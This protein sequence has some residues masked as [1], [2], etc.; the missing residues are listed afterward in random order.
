MMSK[1]VWNNMRSSIIMQRDEGLLIDD[2]Q[3]ENFYIQECMAELDYSGTECQYDD[4]NIIDPKTGNPVSNDIADAIHRR[5]KQRS[6]TE[7]ILADKML[8]Q[9]DK[10]EDL[11]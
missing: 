4:G 7:S 10:L 9:L 5:V 1:E 11:S 2:T 3:R 8:R 6:G